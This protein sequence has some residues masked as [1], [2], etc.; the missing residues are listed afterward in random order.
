M[1][2]AVAG[3]APIPYH[4]TVC[5]LSIHELKGGN[6]VNRF[7]LVALTLVVAACRDSAPADQ[8]RQQEGAPPQTTS[9]QSQAS[10]PLSI[11]WTDADLEKTASRVGYGSAPTAILQRKPGN[12]LV[13]APETAKDHIAMPFT[14]LPPYTGSRSLELIVDAESPGGQACAANL[15]DQAFNVLTTVPCTAI[16]EQRQTVA[17]APGVAS[18]RVY[19][20]SASR[21][22][23]QLP[24]RLRVI[25]HR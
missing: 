1:R 24:H 6:P 18:V 22:P 17:V 9:A 3:L 16:G 14:P 4:E 11:E 21:E 12:A 10:A 8:G 2:A 25:E 5:P 20:L 13:F 7:A 23:I 19:F 15:Q